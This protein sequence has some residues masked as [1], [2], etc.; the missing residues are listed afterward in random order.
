MNA[1]VSIFW[2][3]RDLR[4]LDNAGLYHALHASAD[5]LPLFI[6]DKHILD[7]LE[8]KSDKRVAFIHKAIIGIQEQ[9]M[10]LG[11]SMEVYYGY[12]LEVFK[13]LTEKYTIKA[14]F[15]NHDYEP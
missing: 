9:L 4:L 15:T 14:V 1:T 6:F 10:K 12:P 5:V 3:R 7:D 8:D 2:F 13:A 11:S